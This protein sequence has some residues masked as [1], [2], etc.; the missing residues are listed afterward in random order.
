MS[1]KLI[2]RDRAEKAIKEYKIINEKV[3]LKFFKELETALKYIT[4]NLLA[5]QLRYKNM[6][7]I[8]L[9]TF[10]SSIHYKINE[11]K[12]IVRVYALHSMK[13]NPDD[14]Y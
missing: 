14:R 12:N 11:Q 10:P 8:H 9:K 3:G 7:M 5:F 2:I 1:Y 6:R 4:K 13:T